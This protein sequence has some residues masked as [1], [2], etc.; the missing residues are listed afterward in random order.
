MTPSWTS[1][2]T[3]VGLLGALAFAG[4]CYSSLRH[5]LLVFL[6][7]G[8]IRG[9]QIGAFSGQDMTQGMLPVEVLA[10]V[11][12]AVWIL[13]RGPRICRAP[14]N[15]PLFMIVP[16]LFLSMV[17]GFIWFDPS[18]PVEHLKVGVAFGQMMI[19][20]WIIG[21]YIVAADVVRD[22][23][24]IAAVRT[25]IMVLAVPSLALAV[26]PDATWR[27]FEWSTTFGLPAS[28]LAFAQFFDERSLQ[29]RLGLLVLTLLPIVYGYEVG[30]AFFYAYV[31][32][33][34]AVIAAIR[35][36][37]LMIACAPFAIAAYIVA[38]PLRSGSLMP[39]I[40]QDAVDSERQQQSL[41]GTGGRDALVMYGLN[42]WARAPIIGVGPGNVYPYMIRYSGWG[43]P[44]NQYLN[45]LIEG[46]VLSFAW[47]A[48][49]AALSVRWALRAWRRCA[50]PL[51]RSLLLA[52]LGMFSAMLAGGFFGDF[53]I[54]S[55]RN[56]GIEALAVYYVQW[57]LL[58]VMAAI[59]SAEARR[60]LPANE[61]GW[62]AAP[63]HA[64]TVEAG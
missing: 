3:I 11:L 52:W 19:I 25:V 23:E 18:V 58:G 20:L 28:S 48:A 16:C 46:G 15:L 51:R 2:A 27:Y 56:G 7:A 64:P 62:S 60:P 1:P 4:L 21:L 35:A 44:H 59:A 30:K 42:V 36:K 50:N 22:D 31:L 8:A 41:G 40:V 45:I 34:M 49:F 6:A 17:C 10:S 13:R 43:T 61:W 24:T 5:G 55:I 39:P 26:A 57:V 33:S 9:V 32:V 53:M 37:R 54:P 12:I 14:F 47:L 29:R 63:A 38:V